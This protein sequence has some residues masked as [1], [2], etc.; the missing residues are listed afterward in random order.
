M[1]NDIYSCCPIYKTNIITLRLISKEDAD[2]LLNCYSDEKSVA[3][4]N[5]DNCNGDTFYYTTIERM[6]KTLDFWSFSYENKYFV[7]LSIIDNKSKDII[8]TIEMFKR[9][10]EDEFNGAGVL[11][12]DLQ[13]NYEKKEYIDEII[14]IANNHFYEDFDV[15]Y[16]ITKAIPIAT[17][18]ID[19]LKEKGYTP[20]NKKFISYDDY[21]V[22]TIM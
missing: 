14:N 6:N 2:Q 4:F 7:R 3:I 12:I 10:A 8:G 16:I 1:K 5:S 11:R 22:R 20:L 21:F 15:N 18:R 17:E 13:S 9:E 19:S